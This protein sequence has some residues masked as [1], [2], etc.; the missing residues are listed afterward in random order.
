MPQGT[1]LGPLQFLL[2]VND[3]SRSSNILNY[4]L[5]ADDTNLYLNSKNVYDLSIGNRVS[6]WMM[7]TNLILNLEKTHY[8][9]FARTNKRVAHIPPLIIDN[10]SVTSR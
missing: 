7:S 8:V 10:I 1:F 3:I 9:V 2:Y 6:D 4:F 5:F